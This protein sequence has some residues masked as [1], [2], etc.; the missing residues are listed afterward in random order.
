MWKVLISWPRSGPTV[1]TP[2]KEKK[3]KERREKERKQPRNSHKLIILYSRK[4]A[5]ITVSAT[6]YRSRSDLGKDTMNI[7]CTVQLRAM[8]DQDHFPS[9]VPKCVGIV[10]AYIR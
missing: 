4:C 10:I 1:I 7:D 9:S 3:G 8:I 2:K 6:G 5:A